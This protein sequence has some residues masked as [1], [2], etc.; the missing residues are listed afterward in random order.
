MES[1]A[2][3]SSS[4]AVAKLE[5][6]SIWLNLKV[7]DQVYTAPYASITL[8]HFSY[9]ISPENAGGDFFPHQKDLAAEEDD[10]SLRSKAEDRCQKL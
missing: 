1:S 10:G 6:S 9:F 4:A 5:D 7:K 8:Y 2:H 3:I